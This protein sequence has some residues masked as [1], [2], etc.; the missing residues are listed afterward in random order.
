MVTEFRPK[1][2]V[3][4]RELN[5]G[6]VKALDKLQ[7]D[8]SIK[9]CEVGDYILSDR[10][11]AERKTTEDFL[12]TWL[13]RRE[14]FSQLIDLAKAYERPLLIIEGVPEELYTLRRINPKAIDA[15]L[16]TISASLRIP[17]IYALNPAEV[18]QRLYHIA[19]REQNTED[20]RYF[21]W[22]GKRSHLNPKEQ[23]EYTISSLND[24]G[25]VTA[26]NLLTHFGNIK[27]IVNAD[28]EQLKEVD[29]IG[30]PTA[31]KIKDFFEREYK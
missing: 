5:S 23:L 30:E 31:R 2:I 9:T 17:I 25:R 20:K 27:A 7:T 28:V 14:L 1:I 19:E 29:K 26:I 21:S 12:S 3:D 10:V 11:A 15:V 22:H 6:V 8:Y 18:A 13:E 4:S 16:D 24:V